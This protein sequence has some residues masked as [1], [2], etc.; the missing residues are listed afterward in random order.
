MIKGGTPRILIRISEVRARLIC[1]KY[2]GPYCALGAWRQACGNRRL[3]P[4]A[5]H[6]SRLEAARRSVAARAVD[7]APTVA[8]YRRPAL[9]GCEPSPRPSLVNHRKTRL[10]GVC[11]KQVSKRLH[12]KAR[13]F[14]RGTRAVSN[15]NWRCFP[16]DAPHH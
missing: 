6:T 3:V 8:T 11:T 12:T 1:A 9:A 14:L 5:E 16:D 13:R 7:L 10:R 2:F 4:A 15:L